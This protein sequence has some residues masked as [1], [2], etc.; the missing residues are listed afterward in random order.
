MKKCVVCDNEISGQKVKYCG[1]NC[2]QK[3]HYH[4][5]KN[6]TNTYHSQTI[7][8]YKR[9]M[10]LIELKGGKCSECG[11]KKNISSLHFHHTNPEEKEFQ[12]DARTLSNKSMNLLLI[13]VEKCI[14]LCSNCHGEKHHPESDWNNVDRILSENSSRTIT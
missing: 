8:A 12:L 13:E 1:N 5:L 14:L 6:Q 2:K 11:Y 10:V 9:K 7:R 3:D 4:R